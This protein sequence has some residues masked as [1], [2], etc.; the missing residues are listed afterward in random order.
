MSSNSA[1]QT[2]KE[3]ATG[4]SDAITVHAKHYQVGKTV[5]QYKIPWFL[6]GLW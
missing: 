2:I 3:A 4:M 6:L 1:V 5:N